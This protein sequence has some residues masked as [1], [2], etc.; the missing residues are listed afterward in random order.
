LGFKLSHRPALW[1][2][3]DSKG[4]SSYFALLVSWALEPALPLLIDAAPF[5]NPQAQF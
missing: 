3:R 4:Y 2:P 5:R 1:S